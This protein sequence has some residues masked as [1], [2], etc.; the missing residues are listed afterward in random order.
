MAGKTENCVCGG[1]HRPLD[2]NCL[3]AFLPRVHVDPSLGW[4]H[5]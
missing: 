2:Q 1:M 3:L 5:S 4:L